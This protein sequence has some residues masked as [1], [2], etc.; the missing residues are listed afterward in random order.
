MARTKAAAKKGGVKI[1]TKP[2]SKHMR[3]Q[4]AVSRQVNKILPAVDE[5][6]VGMLF[7]NINDNIKLFKNEFVQGNKRIAED[8]IFKALDQAR[9][10]EDRL[11]P[12]EK[13]E[14]QVEWKKMEALTGDCDWQ[15]R[16]KRMKNNF[17]ICR[18]HYL[19]KDLVPL[20]K[21]LKKLLRNASFLLLFVQNA[22]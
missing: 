22:Q 5:D 7:K 11:F 15:K 21:N 14:I 2:Q 10:V 19:R 17:S 12:F 4:E 20:K 13:F 16:F 1:V 6:E 3:S 8:Y 9:D 18:L